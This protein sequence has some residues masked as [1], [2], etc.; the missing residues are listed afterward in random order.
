[1]TENQSL[2]I[3]RID[4]REDNVQQALDALREKLSPR[5]D[6]VS[7][8]G[9]QRTIAVF[10]QPLSPQQVVEKICGDVRREGLE[11]VLRYT[12]QLDDAQL[13]AETLAS[14]RGR[15]GCR[16]PPGGARVFG[17]G[18][19]HP[20]QHP[21]LSARHPASRRASIQAPR[22]HVAAA[23]RSLAPGRGLRSGRRGRLSVDR[24]DG[25]GAGDGRRSP[26]DRGRGAADPVRRQ[27]SRRA[28]H[29]L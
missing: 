2:R 12:A 24:A 22:R 11:A 16:A 21:G 13:N 17:N 9:R 8:R 18:P 20:R 10:G 14:P 25:R 7:E 29:L 4:T 1:M 5:G 19:P 26:R 15:D 28:G 3:S 6:V 27:P 23:L